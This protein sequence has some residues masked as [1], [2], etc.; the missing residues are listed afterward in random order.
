[1]KVTLYLSS[2]VLLGGV[3]SSCY[4]N[5]MLVDDDVYIMK[6]AELP[7]GESLIDETNYSTYKYKQDRG[8]TANAYYYDPY[9][10]A[11]MNACGCDPFYFTAFDCG[12][13]SRNYGSSGLFDMYYGYGYF[14]AFGNYFMNPY[15]HYGANQYSYYGNMYSP[16]YNPYGGFYFGNSYSSPYFFTNSMFY[17]TNVYPYSNANNIVS[18][19]G[20]IYNSHSG[21]R[22]SIS[23]YSNS[24]N[25]ASVYAIKAHSSSASSNGGHEIVSKPVTSSLSVGQQN[26]VVRIGSKEVVGS[27]RNTPMNEIKP[28]QGRPVYTSTEVR[29]GSG[30][31]RSTTGNPINARGTSIQ[32]RPM[33]QPVNRETS[34]GS[35]GGGS[36][37]GGSSQPASGV[38]RN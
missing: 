21:P 12:W 31:S 35:V 1:M 2:F 36:R 25:R 34:G 33:N 14:N 11:A 5:R 8:V 17:G 27:V 20:S 22:G 32:E 24:G 30:V 28:S 38:R 19:S 4:S 16:Y 23:G 37:N 9:N 29:N 13:G 18:N 3:L 15:E 7:V 6:N 26:A 10:I